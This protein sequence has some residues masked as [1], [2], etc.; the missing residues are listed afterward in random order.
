[1]PRTIGALALAFILFGISPASRSATLY[2]EAHL[3][4]SSEA[5]PNASPGTGYAT[6]LIDTTARTFHLAADF[7]GLLGTTTAAHIHAATM[8]PNA[9]TAGVATQVPSFGGF[10]LGVGSG[11]YSQTFDM[12]LLSS[13][14]PS[15]VTANG[16][17]A[18]GAE[19]SFV[20]AVAAERAYLNIHT[21][22]YPG[23]EIRGFFR[24][25]PEPSSLALM[26][27]GGLGLALIGRRRLTR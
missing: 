8:F 25:V 12:T 20:A 10:P 22:L 6:L 4:G 15:F 7:S 11:A 3:D 14:N 17:T 13:W 19:S 18:A 5:P 21:T 27:A 16:G 2:Y 1:M 23:G 26:V 9:G 24:A